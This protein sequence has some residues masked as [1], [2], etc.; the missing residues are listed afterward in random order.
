MLVELK[1]RL[2]RTAKDQ[3][4]ELVVLSGLL[5]HFVLVMYLMNEL[6]VQ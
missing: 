4:V 2:I 6:T 1:F 3:T 5:K